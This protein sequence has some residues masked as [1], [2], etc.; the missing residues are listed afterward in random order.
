MARTKATAR[1]V[2]DKGPGWR[3]RRD[4]YHPPPAPKLNPNKPPV[5]N[6]ID[7]D[8]TLDP[9]CVKI[10][11]LKEKLHRAIVQAAKG[12][13]INEKDMP[14]CNELFKEL[15]QEPMTPHYLHVRTHAP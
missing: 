12:D 1:K 2:A 15:A 10:M 3:P 14:D 7:L 8:Y 4:D 13:G 9:T 5:V 11:D 6:L